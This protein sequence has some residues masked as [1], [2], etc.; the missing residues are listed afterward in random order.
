MRA[1]A[2]L[3]LDKRRKLAF[4]R[5]QAPTSIL[6]P[7]VWA[8]S[9]AKATD[10]EPAPQEHMTGRSHPRKCTLRFSP[11]VYKEGTIHV[12]FCPAYRRSLPVPTDVTV[13]FLKNLGCICTP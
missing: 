11:G 7:E 12:V 1:A 13:T 9:R 3:V 8:R 4:P 6:N 5:S 10:R 2:G